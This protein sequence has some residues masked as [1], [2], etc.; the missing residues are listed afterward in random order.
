MLY[1]CQSVFTRKRGCLRRPAGGAA[2]GF[3]SASGDDNWAVCRTHVGT[4]RSRPVGLTDT[5]E[6]APFMLTSLRDCDGVAVQRNIHPIAR[7]DRSLCGCR[8]RRPLPQNLHLADG[9]DGHVCGR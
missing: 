7:Y 3:S 8:Q 9:V 1:L 4:V 2:A 5:A 6:A